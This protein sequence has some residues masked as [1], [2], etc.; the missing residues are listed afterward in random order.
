MLIPAIRGMVSLITVWCGLVSLVTIVTWWRKP[1]WNKTLLFSPPYISHYWVRVRGG[2]LK[3][4]NNVF[5]FWMASITL[6]SMLDFTNYRFIGSI[7]LD[8]NLMIVYY[9]ILENTV[10]KSRMAMNSSTVECACA[11]AVHCDAPSPHYWWMECLQLTTRHFVQFPA[12]FAD[13]QFTVLNLLSC[14]VIAELQFSI[15]S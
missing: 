5:L 12:V 15:H 4:K 10:T 8:G 13:C 2:I 14:E 11:A 6:I 9:R 1:F 3:L 7:I